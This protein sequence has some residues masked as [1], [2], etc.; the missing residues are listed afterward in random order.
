[1]QRFNSIQHLRGLAALGVLVF[2]AVAYVSGY[3][4]H[5]LSQDYVRVGEAGVDIFFVISGFILTI[6]TQST[7]SGKVFML[8][9]LARVG[10]P[11]WGV[12]IAL[13]AM[14][15]LAPEAFRSFHWHGSDLLLSLAFIPSI[16][17]DG[18][19]FPLLEPGW[20]LSLEMLF[21]LLLAF[22]LW[23]SPR[24]RAGAICLVLFGLAGLG[25][26][27]Q[28]PQGRSIGWF[29]T[30]PIV[31]EFGFGIAIAQAYLSGLRMR[32]GTAFFLLLLGLGSLAVSA[33]NP[34]AS[35]APDRTLIYGL[36]ALLIVGSAVFLEAEGG[37]FTSRSLVGLGAI[38]YSLYLTHVLTLAVVAKVL[39]GHFSSLAGNYAMLAIAMGASLAAAFVYYRLIERP[40]LKLGWTAQ[41]RPRQDRRVAV[42]FGK[43]GAA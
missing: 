23:L 15:L 40:A 36:P 25:L 14:T 1:M 33:F 17:R 38:S 32:R 9:R 21:Y 4:G 11:Y 27:L 12:I 34:P 19:I 26:W 42:S 35:F 10:V 20:T 28:L 18:S 31:I 5:R 22:S 6:A 2:H 29:Y 37:W 41:H 7:R 24:G 3:G 8:G 39:Q 30:Q 43:A 16:I 13:A